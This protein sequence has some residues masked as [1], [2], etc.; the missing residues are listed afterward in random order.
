ML[1]S[2]MQTSVSYNTL[3]RVVHTSQRTTVL[4]VGFLVEA[5]VNGGQN[6]VA[7]VSWWRPY[8]ISDPNRKNASRESIIGG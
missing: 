7:T 6:N 8:L 4:Q 5:T 3:E 1:K 2:F